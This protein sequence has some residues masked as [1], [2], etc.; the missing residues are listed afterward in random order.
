MGELGRPPYLAHRRLRPG[1]GNVVADRIGKQ[2]GVLQDDADEPPQA[3]RRIHADILAIEQDL[4][5]IE[6]IEA[7]QQVDDSRLAGPCRPD[8]CNLVPRPDLEA[9]VVDDA[10]L[11][12]I[13]EAHM[14]K[15]DLALCIR[16]HLAALPLLVRLVEH[17]KDALRARQCCLDLAVELR[18]LID[19]PREL[20]RVDREGRDDADRDPA[21]E[22]EV[23]TEDGDDDEREIRD[24]V[25]ERAHR[26]ADALRADAGLRQ[27]VRCLIERR[28]DLPLARIRLDRAH[29]RDLL[30]DHAVELA[31]QL[32]ALAEIAAHLL[33]DALRRHN[34]HD[35]RHPGQQCQRHTEG[36]HD[37]RRADD[38]QD[39]GKQGAERSRDDRRDVVGIVRHAA[40]EVAVRMAVNRGERQAVDFLEEVFAQAQDDA[41]AQARAQ[42]PLEEEQHGVERTGP[43][44]P[45]EDARHAFVCSGRDGVDGLAHKYR[46]TDAG[47]HADGDDERQ[48][49]DAPP[50]LTEVAQ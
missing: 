23:R 12:H 20:L 48:E 31:E 18:H 28:D 25:H 40:H 11:G 5:F 6:L 34:G 26:G 10:L 19:G 50:L 49:H 13:R 36:Q 8:E 43:E 3:D 22:R 16:R 37:R 44:H 30:L 47:R 24:R 45:P 39:A 27:A 33:G 42:A 15:L 17:G 32:L 41:L 46:C 1:V 21:L 7:H 2:H 35:G 38:R 4:P 29:S 14:A 9:E